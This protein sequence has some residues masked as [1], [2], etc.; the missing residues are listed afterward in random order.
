MERR[1]FFRIRDTVEIHCQ[2]LASAEAA[3]LGELLRGGAHGVDY[4]ANFDN[5][6]HSL[7]EAMRVQSELAAELLGLINRKLNL[8]IRQLDLDAAALTEPAFERRLVSLSACGLGLVV[9]RPL[10]AGV[11]VRVDLRLDPGELRV[12][13]LGRVVACEPL[14]QRHADFAG[15]DAEGWFLRLDFQAIAHAD[16][17]LLIQHVVRCQSRQL[18]RRRHPPDG[19]N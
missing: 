2:P 10:E 16:Q 5:R 11:P 7:L 8:L 13:V 9:A 18:Q 12:T 3:A 6:I 15:S 19:E 1:R 17:E 4:A 14:D